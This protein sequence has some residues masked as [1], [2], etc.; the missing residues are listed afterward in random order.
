MRRFLREHIRFLRET[1]KG[2]VSEAE[3]RQIAALT[4][5]RKAGY[6]L[7]QPDWD[8]TCLNVVYLASRE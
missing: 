2:R 4:D 1:V 8:I 7:R 6:F 5:A 3:W